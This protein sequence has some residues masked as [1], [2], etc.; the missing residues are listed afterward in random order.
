[1]A[2]GGKRA[3]AGRKPNA[4]GKKAREVSDLTHGGR[5]AGAG[6]TLGAATKKTRAIADQA[7]ADGN[8]TPLEV[9]LHTMRAAL[10]DGDLPFAVSIARDAAPYCHPRLSAITVKENI[11]IDVSTM[12]DEELEARIRHLQEAGKPPGAVHSDGSGFSRI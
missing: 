9:M 11:D 6:R 8:I 4:A 5:R 2:R 7:A 12:T 10:L 1:M 3:G